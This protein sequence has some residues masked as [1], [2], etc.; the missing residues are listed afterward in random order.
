MLTILR[1]IFQPFAFTLMLLISFAIESYGQCESSCTNSDQETLD[2]LIEIYC[3]TDGENWTNNKGWTQAINNNTDCD[4]CQ[5]YGITCYN[6]KLT[7]IDL[8]ENNLRGTLPESFTKLEDLKALNFSDNALQGFFPSPITTKEI[9]NH[10]I[11]SNNQFDG[12]IP[13]ITSL[14]YFEGYPEIILLK[15]N[16]FTGN[17]PT[18]MTTYGWR[19]IDVS[20]NELDG[21][22][23]DLVFTNLNPEGTYDFSNNKLT[24]TLPIGFT[25]LIP[26]G[27]MKL[28]NNNFSG[29]FPEELIG[30]CEYNILNT[31]GN[32]ELPWFGQFFQYCAINGTLENQYNAPCNDGNDE[33]GTDD[34]IREDCTC[35][36]QITLTEG[37]KGHFIIYPNPSTTHL[38]INQINSQK[39]TVNIYNS[40]GQNV[41][42][43]HNVNNSID[44]SHLTNGVYFISI[45]SPS[46]LTR[47]SYKIIKI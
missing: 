21:I 16:K 24:G 10:F 40:F 13:I 7:E 1:S 11:I 31:T 22:F 17:I 2:I 37:L 35:G 41:D 6:N 20:Y 42:N 44:I 43:H 30:F 9:L 39:L 29:C 4:Y 26:E 5:W 18:S 34:V 25:D 36:V 23:E 8:S 19:N 14:D 27:K 12:P 32:P 45:T 46:S 33:N 3:N 38:Y 47:S 28:Q 15:N